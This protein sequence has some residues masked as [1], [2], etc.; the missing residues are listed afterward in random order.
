MKLHKDKSKP[1]KV[2]D[3][4]KALRLLASLK[5]DGF[6]DAQKSDAFEEL[7]VMLGG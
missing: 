1:V 4:E 2:L 5:S 7:K 3:Q 6:T